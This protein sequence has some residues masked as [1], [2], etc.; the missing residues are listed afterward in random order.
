MS[1]IRAALGASPTEKIK[2][3]A[4]WAPKT[5]KKEG[6]SAEQYIQLVREILLKDVRD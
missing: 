5:L 6:Q 3:L 1:S 2:L 4:I